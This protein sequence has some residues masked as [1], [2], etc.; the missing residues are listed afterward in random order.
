M[1]VVPKKGIT[2]RAMMSGADLIV[3]L[4]DRILGRFAAARY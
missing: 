4:A 1:I 2:M 3:S